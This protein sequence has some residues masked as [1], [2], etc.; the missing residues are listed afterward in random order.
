V[1]PMV[2]V[3]AASARTVVVY[4]NSGAMNAAAGASSSKEF[5][6]EVSDWI[7]KNTMAKIKVIIPPSG[8]EDTKLNILLASGEQIDIFWG[9]WTDYA[10]KGV[11]IPINKLLQQN[12]GAIKKIWPKVAW[13]GMTDPDKKIWGVPRFTPL[14]AHPLWVRAD[15]LKKLNLKMPTTID[16]LEAVLKAFKEH[17]PGGEGTI[18]LLANMEMEQCLVGAFTTYGY[19]NWL[20]KKDKKIKPAELQPGFRD[21]VAK[22]H[23]WY[24]KGYITPE[25]T[26]L[27]RN[28]ARTMIKQNKVG[29]T[30]MWYS[31]VTLSMWALQQNTPTA[32]YQFPV[33]GLRGPM[34]KAE[35]I[36][37]PSTKGALFSAKSKNSAVSMKVLNFLYSSPVNYMI[38]WLGP[39][40]KNW[41][42]KDRRK[43]IYEIV[44]NRSGYYSDYCFT[45]G[46]M[47]S[48]VLGEDPQQKLHQEY[49]RKHLTDF[50][51]GKMPFDAGVIYDPAVIKD[52]V[53]GYGDIQRI[54][55][56]EVS[57][58]IMGARPMSEWNQFIKELYQAG[59]D[60]WIEAHTE[61]Y[62][63]QRKI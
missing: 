42:W 38:A 48:K 20:D 37:G 18:P 7:T 40:G 43:C 15:W 33:G 41:K 5:L 14:D 28:R 3:D 17:Q 23:D 58:F 46:A 31:N 62:K 19:S 6:D 13:Q 44:P 57:K 27:T 61:L 52:K 34:G 9:N 35:T 25:F 45:L 21:F 63:R 24:T 60:K 36:D 16:Q 8:Q 22:M 53:P 59:L 26:T 12:G 11:I 32:D 54:K 56:E 50:K 30:A 49:V 47:G 1:A 51:R 10:S 39:E 55:E 29:A 4:Q 2:L